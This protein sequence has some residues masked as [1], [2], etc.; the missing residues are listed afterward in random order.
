ML[1]KGR[2]I[3]R[4]EAMNIQVNTDHNIQGGHELNAFVERSLNDAF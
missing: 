3:L 4:G 1:Q 2:L